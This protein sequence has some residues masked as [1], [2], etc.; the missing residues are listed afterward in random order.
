MGVMWSGPI[1]PMS[2]ERTKDFI[3]PRPAGGL[4]RFAVCEKPDTQDHKFQY[5]RPLPPMIG[6]LNFQDHS[7]DWKNRVVY[8]GLGFADP[9][10]QGKGYGTELLRWA[11]EY[12]FCE[13]GIHKVALEA[14]SFN[15]NAANMYKKVYVRTVAVVVMA[16]TDG[17]QSKSGFTQEGRLRK[18]VLRGGEWH[19]TLIFGVSLRPSQTHSHC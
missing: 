11:L 10:H 16:Y 4:P 9:Q 5:T 17:C 2:R 8:L 14:Y 1:G 7:F 15:Q 19:D 12:S 18:T 6:V 3:K 13:L